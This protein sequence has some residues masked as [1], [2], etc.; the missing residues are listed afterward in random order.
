MTALL[1][2]RVMKG[3]AENPDQSRRKSKFLLLFDP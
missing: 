3:E 2:R 1:N